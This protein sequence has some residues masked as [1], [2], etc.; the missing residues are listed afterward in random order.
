MQL[1]QNASSES[2]RQ[3][4]RRIRGG[5]RSENGLYLVT[6]E[7][8]AEGLGGYYVANMMSGEEYMFPWEKARWLGPKYRQE[9]K[10][11]L[12]YD[13][14]RRV[15]SPLVGIDGYDEEVSDSSKKKKKMKYESWL[16]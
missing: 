11:E 6:D 13:M 5:Y 3:T 7:L 9:E 4:Y 2:F 14:P 1:Q 8:L 16:L 15:G 10:Q 12:D